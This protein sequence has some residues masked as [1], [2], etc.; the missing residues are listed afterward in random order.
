VIEA[1]VYGIPD[2]RLGEEIGATL[3]VRT[4]VDEDGLRGF[5]VD[6]L[7]RFKIPRYI[8][9]TFESLPRIAS[10]KIDKITLRA[11]H[12]QTLGL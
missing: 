1:S 9:L 11:K 6:H 7:A 12:R 2:A 3:Y 4:P 5:L 10:G 8:A